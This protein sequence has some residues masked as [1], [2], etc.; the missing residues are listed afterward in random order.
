M[1]SA[2]GLTNAKAPGRHRFPTLR[3][4]KS[5]FSPMYGYK[6]SR[7][8]TGGIFVPLRYFSAAKK[9][10]IPQTCKGFAENFQF[11]CCR[12]YFCGVGKHLPEI[13]FGKKEERGGGAG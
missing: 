10:K 5:L 11:L 1:C 12:T 3:H 8:M 2:A 6:N 4:G 9:I 13:D 7:Y